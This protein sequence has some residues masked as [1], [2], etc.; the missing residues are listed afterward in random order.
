HHGD[1]ARDHN[2]RL[3]Q[4]L[5]QAGIATDMDLSGR[6]IKAQFKMADRENARFVVVVGDDE[7]AKQCVQLKD[8]QSGTQT[9]VDEAKLIETLRAG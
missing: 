5:R 3:A 4:T 1:K 9:S 2:L 6:A 8:L 7:L